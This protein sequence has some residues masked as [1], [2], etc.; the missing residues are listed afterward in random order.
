LRLKTSLNRNELFAGLCVIGFANGILIRI[1]EGLRGRDWVDVLF[2]TFDISIILWAALIAGAAFLFQAP[3]APVTR[4]DAMAVGLAAAAFLV[5]LAPLSWMAIT[6][7]AVYAALTSPQ[8]SL[9]RR[10]GWILAA[11]TIPMFWSRIVFALFSNSILEFDAALVGWVVGTERA[12]NAIAFTDGSGYLWIAPSCSSL[13]NISLAILCSVL[14]AQLTQ[15]GQSLR[16]ATWAALACLA[17]LTI[18]VVR[19]SLI[20]MYSQYFDLLH[21]PIGATVA[22]WTTLLAVVGICSLGS[23]PRVAARR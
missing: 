14:F 12:G 22:N 1:V 21:G 10:G 8:G 7:I 3:G 13:A 9:A 6:G 20:G 16:Q 11:M 4:R 5:P 15:A 23:R 18:N 17:V 2:N 19:L